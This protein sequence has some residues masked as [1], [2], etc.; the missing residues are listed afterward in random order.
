MK[1]LL[2][3]MIFVIGHQSCTFGYDLG[4]SPG[5]RPKPQAKPTDRSQ[6]PPEIATIKLKDL[7]NFVI[8]IDKDAKEARLIIPNSLIRSLQNEMGTSGS[9]LSPNLINDQPTVSRI[10]T[11]IGG[12]LMALSFLFGGLWLIRHRKLSVPNR[13][14][15]AFILS[16][17]GIGTASLVYANAGPPP[18]VGV[19]TGKIF[20]STV[21]ASKQALGEIR[22]E[23]TN[24][25]DSI[26]LIVPDSK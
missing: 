2:L 16:L 21:Q 20:S 10:G 15:I 3:M 19:I 13:A 6:S 22:I 24:E 18:E 4:P 9:F 12:L 1:N 23:T 11:I 14:V 7:K 5:Q 25:G 17:T 26:K 8:Q